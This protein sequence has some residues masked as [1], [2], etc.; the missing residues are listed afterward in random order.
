MA[1]MRQASIEISWVAEEKA[2]SRAEYT[3][4]SRWLNGL[5]GGVMS[6]ERSLLARVDMP[7]G[8]SILAV[9]RRPAS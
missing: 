5:L 7:F 4:I 8:S 6:V 9:C 1:S 2:T 3:S